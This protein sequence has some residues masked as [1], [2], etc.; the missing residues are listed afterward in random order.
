MFAVSLETCAYL[1]QGIF[2]QQ[3]AGEGGRGAQ[4][5]RVRHLLYSL[6][7]GQDQGGVDERH[8]D[9]GVKFI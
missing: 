5:A 4:E 6:P 8:D 3:R 7:D 1:H 2:T 9:V